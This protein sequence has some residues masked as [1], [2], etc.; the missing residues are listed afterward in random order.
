[1]RTTID[2]A[3]RLV[4]PKRLRDRLALGEGAEVE[5]IER[6]GVLEIRPVPATVEVRADDGMPVA[7]PVDPLPPLTDEAVRGT[8]EHVRR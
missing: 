6:D 4:V 1:M 8:L 3:G 2:R 5:V 7:H